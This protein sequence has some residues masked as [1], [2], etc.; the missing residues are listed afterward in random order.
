MFFHSISAKASDFEEGWVTHICPH[1][2]YR[3]CIV[4]SVLLQNLEN[5]QM[6]ITHTCFKDRITGWQ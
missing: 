1:L 4:Q 2:I 3:R 5:I 6:C